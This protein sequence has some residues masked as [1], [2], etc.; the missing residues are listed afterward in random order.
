MSPDP[1]LSSPIWKRTWPL[2]T[3]LLCGLNTI[4][5]D[6]RRV[7][8]PTPSMDTSPSPFSSTS[9]IWGSSVSP[10][11]APGTLRTLA[12]QLLDEQLIPVS[13]ATGRSLVLLIVI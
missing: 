5:F 9:R 10:A 11:L 4:V 13:T 2:V 7:N 6:D 1:L 12:S 3:P 8:L